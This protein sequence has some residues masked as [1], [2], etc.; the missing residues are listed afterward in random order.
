[1]TRVI[2]YGFLLVASG[3]LLNVLSKWLDVGIFKDQD[4]W[5]GMTLLLIGSFMAPKKNYP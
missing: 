4:F 2:G 3:I 5:I 1:M